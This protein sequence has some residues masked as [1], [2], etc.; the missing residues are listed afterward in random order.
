MWF[1]QFGS[2][3]VDEVHHATS[4]SIQDIMKKL[5]NCPD[6]VGLTG[7]LHDA[8]CNEMVLRGLFGQV[9]KVTTTKELMDRDSV[10]KNENYIVT[11][12]YTDL[13]RRALPN[14]YQD[15]VVFLMNHEARNEFLCRLAS[16]IHGN[17]LLLFQRIEHGKKLFDNI[18]TDKEKLYI[19]GRD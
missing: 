8:K 3:V 9:C 2:V 4:K 19:A 1:S 15:E 13:D 11:L 17:T 12:D 5:P 16:K 18:E 7:T 6:R 10:A 14:R